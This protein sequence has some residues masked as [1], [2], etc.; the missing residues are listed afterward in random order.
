MK[1]L[2]YLDKNIQYKVIA[3]KQEWVTSVECINTVGEALP[4]LL[5]FKGA[6]INSKWL[7]ERSPQDWHLA[8]SKNGW[9]SNHLGLEW[10]KKVFNL[11]TRE[12]TAGRQRL[13]IADR[14]SSYI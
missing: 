2:V 3:G 4:P 13:L 7:N 12:K 1:V 9:T 10:L 8:T 5:I 11:L 6:N 14:H